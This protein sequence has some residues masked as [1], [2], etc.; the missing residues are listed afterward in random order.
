M[1]VRPVAVAFVVTLALLFSAGPEARAAGPETTFAGK[2]LL[3]DKRFPSQAKSVG[4]YVSALRKQN[5]SNFWENKEKKE[6]MIHI[7]AFF[8][9]PLNDL[10]VTVKLFD[11]S[12]GNQVFMAGFEQYLDERGQKSIISSM[13][14]ERKQFGV[15]KQILVTIVDSGGRV[16]ASGKFKI[17]GEGEKY[18][19]KVDFS[20]E[21]AGK[22]DTGTEE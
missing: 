10:E 20:D 3:S 2:V 15:N 21:E 18:S 5:K 12:N 19:G 8:K 11:I 9:K 13:K 22:A 1:V 16:L 14:L 7:A 6:W 17:L 4:A